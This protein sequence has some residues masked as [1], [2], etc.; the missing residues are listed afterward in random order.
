MT[1]TLWIHRSSGSDMLVR[2]PAA[3]DGY[4]FGSM[5]ILQHYEDDYAIHSWD[6]S[7]YATDSMFYVGDSP[8]LQ[9]S[10]H[11][12]T[13]HPDGWRGRSNW[14]P[15]GTFL[16]TEDEAM[17]LGMRSE[18]IRETPDST[19]FVWTKDSA[20]AEGSTRYDR[21]VWSDWVKPGYDDIDLSDVD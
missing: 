17:T 8:S 6:E 5:F 12:G 2:F 20:F 19:P 16:V 9:L 18:G 3:F 13:F 4:N 14:A 21:L 11:T 15:S 10:L 7:K 1:A